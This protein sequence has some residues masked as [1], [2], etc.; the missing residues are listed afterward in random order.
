MI[1][2]GI[3]EDQLQKLRKSTPAGSIGM[4]INGNLSDTGSPILKNNIETEKVLPS[5]FVAA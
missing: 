3:V 5:Q 1:V 4:V 2:N